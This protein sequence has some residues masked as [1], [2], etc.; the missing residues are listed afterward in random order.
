MSPTNLFLAVAILIAL[1]SIAMLDGGS[2]FN[3]AG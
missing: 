1:V 2:I 3:L